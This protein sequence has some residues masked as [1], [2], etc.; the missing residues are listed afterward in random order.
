VNSKM[1][2]FQGRVMAPPAATV[3]V[4]HDE[5]LVLLNAVEMIE[6]A[7]WRALEAANSAEALEVLA[8]HED[9]DVLFTDINMPGQMDGW[10]SQPVC[11]S[12]ARMCI[13]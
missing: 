11:T 2:A 8:R 3:L 10:S 1:A 6:E 9:V 12:C 13:S 4:V 5:A 7:G